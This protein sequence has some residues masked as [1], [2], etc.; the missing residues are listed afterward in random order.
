MPHTNIYETNEKTSPVYSFQMTDSADGTNIDEAA[1]QALTL[2]YYNVADGTIINSRENQDIKDANQVDVS[3]AG[4]VTWGLTTADTIIVDVTTPIGSFEKHRA[5][6]TW[7][8]IS[9]DTTTKTG[10][11]QIDILVRNLLKVT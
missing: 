5:L 8:Y 10:R 11:D 4:L 7:T 9:S 6:F 1:L 3:V 2:T